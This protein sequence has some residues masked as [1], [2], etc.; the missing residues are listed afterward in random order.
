MEVMVGW[1]SG[2]CRGSVLYLEGKVAR[3]GSFRVFGGVGW[4]VFGNQWGGEDV[5]CCVVSMSGL[6]GV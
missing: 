3:M 1:C 5:C 2:V 4:Q 6:M